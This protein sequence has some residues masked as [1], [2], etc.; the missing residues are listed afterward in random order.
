MNFFVHSEYAEFKLFDST[1][2]FLVGQNLFYTTPHQ[3]LTYLSLPHNNEK[4][5]KDR[6]QNSANEFPFE[7]PFSFFHYTFLCIS[8]KKKRYRNKY[9]TTPGTPGRKKGNT[10]ALSDHFPPGPVPIVQSPSCV[11]F[12]GSMAFNSQLIEKGFHQQLSP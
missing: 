11:L 8:S 7:W 4:S 3:L 10:T 6:K 12:C 5:Y 1:N 9:K 2:C